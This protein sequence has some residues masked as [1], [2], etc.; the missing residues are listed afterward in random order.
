MSSPT[1]NA[2]R[3]SRGASF[4]DR[5]RSGNLRDHEFGAVLLGPALLLL[6]GIFLLPML[7]VFLLT[8]RVQ[9]E[10]N[11]QIVTYGLGNFQKLF[12]DEQFGSAFWRT[13]WFGILTVAGSFLVGLPL[14]LLANVKTGWRWVVR[15]A[16][17][18]PWAMPQVITGAMFAWLFNY[19][20]GLFNDLLS[21]L[22]F[23]KVYW[24]SQPTSAAIAFVITTIWKT[25]SFVALILLG[26][27]QS[28]P[29]ELEEAAKVDGASNTQV[30]WR[31]TLPLLRPAIAVAL[32]FRTLSALQVFDIPYA[33]M[34]SGASRSL[35]TLG[36]YIQKYT[37][38]F[39][40]PGYGSTV[41]LSLFAL[42]L[43]ITV[44]YL[45]FVRV[46]TK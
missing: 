24:F 42:A 2:P 40:D 43:V 7:N 4:W 32:I 30:F 1:S 27:L 29:T 34:Q 5:L 18:L 9:D 14:A 44:I 6:A 41:S 22:G 37:A 15:I 23:A 13:I 36:V 20:Y 28:I 21:R 46:E 38:E 25:S 17:L 26:G 39:L 19:E 35:E 11:P 16:L 33:F 31:V 45:R 10:A 12:S 8:L 3:F